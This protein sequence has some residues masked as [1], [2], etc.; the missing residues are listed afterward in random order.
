MENFQQKLIDLIKPT[1]WYPVLRM[2]LNSN[3]FLSI[4]NELKSQYDDGF[5]FTPSLK[6]IFNPFLQCDFNNLKIVIINPSPCPDTCSNGLPFN[7]ALCDSYSNEFVNFN[8]LIKNSFYEN[9]KFTYRK[10]FSTLANQGVLMLNE[11]LT[12]KLN[13]RS[14]HKKLWNP[15]IAYLIEKIDYK[16][17]DITFIL[18]GSSSK[19]EPLI[20]EK[21]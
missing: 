7:R 1:N 17:N 2:F 11:S 4:L 13:F 19:L 14:S 9:E 20:D 5:R 12:T 18:F 16:Y 8:K 6:Q 21:R 15:F 3:E 10:D